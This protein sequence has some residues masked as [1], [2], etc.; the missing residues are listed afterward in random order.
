MTLF[1]RYNDVII[2]SCVQW[3]GTTLYLQDEIPVQIAC[4]VPWRS[5]AYFTK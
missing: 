3:E 4:Y 1:W 2:P 5:E